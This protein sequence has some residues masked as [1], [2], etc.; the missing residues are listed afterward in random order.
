MSVLIKLS[1]NKLTL[2]CLLIV[3][4]YAVVALG[5]LFGLFG[6]GWADPVAAPYQPPKWTPLFNPE[7]LGTDIFGR[8]VFYRVIQG[9]KLAFGVGVIS[10][11]IAIPLAILLG[12]LSGYFGGK[13]DQIIVWFYSTLSSIP[14]IMLLMAVSYALGKGFT[15][16]CIA[17]TATSWIGLARILRGEFMKQKESEYVLAAASIGVSH[18]ARIFKHILPNVLHLIILGF[19]LQFLVAIKS[20]VIL[21]FLGL[22]VIG[23]PSWGVMIDDSKQELVRGVW[24][25]LTAASGAMFGLVLALNVLGDAL[26]DILDPKWKTNGGGH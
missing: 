18:F 13:V 5:A 25:Q 3:I 10:A 14:N 4:L 20:E 24:W 8:S 21:S 2:I 11:G 26:R 1:K 16:V 15:S 12:G 19:S 22:G 23:Q 9:T 7:W 17:L 6:N